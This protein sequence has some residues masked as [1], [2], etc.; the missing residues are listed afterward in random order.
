MCPKDVDNPEMSFIGLP[1]GRPCLVCVLR[2]GPDFLT[3]TGNDFAVTRVSH[4]PSSSPFVKQT[5][6]LEQTLL[7][8]ES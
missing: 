1:E 5:C 4:Q 3:M 6:L 8:A 2:V 7:C